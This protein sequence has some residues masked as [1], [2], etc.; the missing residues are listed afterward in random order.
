M[1]VPLESSNTCRAFGNSD[2]QRGHPFTT[3]PGLYLNMNDPAQCNGTVTAWSSCFHMPSNPMEG[4][5]Y[6]V[7]FLA[8]RRSDRNEYSVVP[9]SI[10]NVRL[11]IQEIGN[12]TF[13]CKRWN[14]HYTERFLVLENDVIGACLFG[15]PLNV[16]SYGRNT[17]VYRRNEDCLGNALGE[18]DTSRN[19]WRAGSVTLHL[20]AHISK[21]I[22]FTGC[23][24]IH[25]INIE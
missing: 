11:S 24:C 18:I 3:Q 23:A 10:H 16:I 7:R 17:E 19:F 15:E 13:M 25:T 2:Q 8:Y 12:N 20:Q 14:L 22:P 4:Q 21:S 1:T 6:S 9:N 5:P